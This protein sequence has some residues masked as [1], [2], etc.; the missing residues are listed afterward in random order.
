MT[1]G[2]G[3]GHKWGSSHQGRRYFPRDALMM[4]MVASYLSIRGG[5]FFFRWAK[6]L[7]A[8]VGIRSGRRGRRRGGRVG[9]S[10]SP[11]AA[12]AHHQPHAHAAGG[13]AAVEQ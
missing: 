9:A 7:G 2:P 1:D 8:G 11:A 5:S 6:V 12:G 4:M 13:G 3:R 10:S